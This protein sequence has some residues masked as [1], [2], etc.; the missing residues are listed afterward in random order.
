MREKS[1]DR[2]GARRDEK[3]SR[4]RD[5][6]EPIQSRK[7]AQTSQQPAPQTPVFLDL[8]LVGVREG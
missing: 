8:R 3:V 4:R 1:Q 5:T 7:E 6:K 2:T